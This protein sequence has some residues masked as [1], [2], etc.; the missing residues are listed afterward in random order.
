MS[1]HQTT[2]FIIA[3][4]AV[5]AL[6]HFL[7]PNIPDGDSF[8]YLYLAKHLLSAPADISA[9]WLP[10]TSIGAYSASL[11]YGAG[12]IILPF[13]K[14][15]DPALAIKL[16]GIIL[17]ALVLISIY[18]IS[19]RH[20]LSF[21]YLLPFAY[22]VIAPNVTFQLLMTRPQTLSLALGALLFSSLLT[23]SYL[24]SFFLSAALAFF[25]LNYI[26]LPLGL[27]IFITLARLVLNRA[28]FWR[29]A[30]ASLVG[31]VLGALARP[32]PIKAL[33]L[34]YIQIIEQ[35]LVKQSNIP[36]LF[37]VENFPLTWGSVLKFF[38]PFVA[39][40]LAAIVVFVWFL[41]LPSN[42]DLKRDIFL[43]SAGILSLVFGFLSIFVARRAYEL[44]T[45]FGLLF[46]AAVLSKIIPD[47]PYRFRS[48]LKNF[49]WFLAAAIFI[50]LLIFSSV[51]TATNLKTI[52]YSPDHRRAVGLWLATNAAPGDFVFNTRWA[53][54]S[55]LV[56]YNPS[57]RYVGGLDPIFQYAADPERYWLYHYL[58][59]GLLSDQTCSL[60]ACHRSD[61]VDT[62]GA[63]TEKFNAR[64]IFLEPAR[65][66]ALASYLAS[67]SRY[68][69]VLDTNKEI[70][71]RI[72]R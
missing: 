72:E 49:S 14:L 20:R 35:S 45:L 36:L 53:D 29:P 54:F 60:N 61:L 25:H 16:S 57:G 21:P 28:F 64:Y 42:R 2:I 31:V 3:A 71:Y 37:G 24:T 34:F 40:W 23:G 15:S 33:R 69:S 11:W 17:T 10:F 46:I 68:T 66:P 39:L 9:S 18:I 26:W 41:F 62:Y 19:R 12:F 30:L 5:S 8:F 44:W 67:D 27:I 4:F 48:A 56:L 1:R 22:L 63:L 55:P 13:A 70:L 59:S 43:W 6:W 58:A 38:S 51:R 65:L 52:A 50:F 7:S 32:E 47:F